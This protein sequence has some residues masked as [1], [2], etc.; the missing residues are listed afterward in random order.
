MT[1]TIL[2]PN[3]SALERDIEESG[4]KKRIEAI[5]VPVGKLW[6]PQTIPAE[7]LPYLAWALSVDT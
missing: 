5:D 2:P 1:D 6:N 7:I 4:G 3:S